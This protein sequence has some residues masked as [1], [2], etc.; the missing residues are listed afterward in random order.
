MSDAPP[1]LYTPRRN[2]RPPTKP[3][4]AAPAAPPPS[5]P[6]DVVSEAE[7][8]DTNLQYYLSYFDLSLLDGV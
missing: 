1:A 8:P 6:S 2:R 7:G 5:S 3:Q 4:G